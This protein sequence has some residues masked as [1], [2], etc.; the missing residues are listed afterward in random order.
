[1]HAV[2]RACTGGVRGFRGWH[3]GHIH[4]NISDYDLIDARGLPLCAIRLTCTLMQAQTRVLIGWEISRV[5]ARRFELLTR[6]PFYLTRI[7]VDFTR[8]EFDPTRTNRVF[9]RLVDAYS[10]KCYTRRKK[11]ATR[12]LKCMWKLLLFIIRVKTNSLRVKLK[13][14]RIE[15]RYVSSRAFHS[16]APS[17][18]MLPKLSYHQYE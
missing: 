14:T 15:I 9:P 10:M 5:C 17:A 3:I 2:V 12:S 16:F 18:Q 7:Q 11:C 1:M 13:F 8:R 6:R 4:D